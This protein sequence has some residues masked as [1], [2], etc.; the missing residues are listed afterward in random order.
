MIQPS[1]GVFPPLQPGTYARFSGVI[2]RRLQVRDQDL[3]D[4]ESVYLAE[5]LSVT[6]DDAAAGNL[7]NNAAHRKI[8]IGPAPSFAF[9][10]FQGGTIQQRPAITAWQDHDP[11]VAIETIDVPDGG[12]FWLAYR[13]T[14]NGDGTWHYE[15]ALYNM[16]SHR[17]ARAF[18]VPVAGGTALTEIGF[19]DVDYHSGDGHDH[20]TYDGTD[21]AV[22]ESGGFIA[23][24]TSTIEEDLNANALRWGTMYNFRFDADAP[25]GPVSATIDLYRLGTPM[26]IQVE[27]LGPGMCL[28]DL[29][30]SGDIGFNDLLAVLTSWGPC[31][32]HCAEDLD[33]DDTVGF[34]DLLMILTAWG[35]CDSR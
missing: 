2:A 31:P 16:N 27:T 10:G 17:S 19:H 11:V 35:P 4:P 12:R 30:E 28:G 9:L 29:D 34:G 25:P 8:R 7:H 1:T 24:S 33:G 5:V 6:R 21:W 18:T 22:T 3:G 14:D 13:V 26:S 15:Y 23:W 20:V 32:P